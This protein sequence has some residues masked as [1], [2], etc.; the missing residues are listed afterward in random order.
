MPGAGDQNKISQR[1]AMCPEKQCWGIPQKQK[2][3]E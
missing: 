1:P 3:G 2:V